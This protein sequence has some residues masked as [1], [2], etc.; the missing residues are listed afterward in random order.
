MCFDQPFD[1]LFEVSG[2][3][4]IQGY[5]RKR[6]R[7]A[8]P[9]VRLNALDETSAARKEIRSMNRSGTLDDVWKIEIISNAE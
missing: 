7:M 2:F 6:V 5:F 1:H 8:T 4:F 3:L 9:P